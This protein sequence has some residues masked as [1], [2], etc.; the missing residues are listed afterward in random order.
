MALRGAAD[1]AR[2][3]ALAARLRLFDGGEKTPAVIDALDEQRNDVRAR[4]FRQ[5]FDKI[6]DIEVG[7]VANRDAVA[8]ADFFILREV[9]QHARDAAALNQKGDVAGREF[10]AIERAGGPDDE[11]IEHVHIAVAVGPTD[12]NPRFAREGAEPLLQPLAVLARLGEA[13]VQDEHGADAPRAA[14]LQR[15]E[16][17]AVRHHHDRDVDRLRNVADVRISPDALDFRPVRID[18]KDRALELR[19]EQML[20]HAPGKLIGVV[21]RADDGDRARIEHSLD[22]GLLLH[23]FYRSTFFGFTGTRRFASLSPV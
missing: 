1:L 19:F 17:P 8:E 13:R 12:A 18:G 21:R 5:V 16:E 15:V 3:D 10:R 7:L 22:D 11:L 4:V 23:A 14:V 9:E 2:N 6:G 20:E